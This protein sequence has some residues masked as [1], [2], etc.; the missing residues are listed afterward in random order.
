[1]QDEIRWDGLIK[2][3]ELKLVAMAWQAKRE[4]AEGKARPMNLD[5]L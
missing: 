5:E 3:T 1:L 2:S 4:I